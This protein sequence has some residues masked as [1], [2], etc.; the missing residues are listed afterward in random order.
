MRS[1][2]LTI[3]MG[4]VF[5]VTGADIAE[6]IQAWETETGG[7]PRNPQERVVE[8]PD[9]MSLVLLIGQSNM[10]GRADIP[11]EDRKPLARALKLNRD[12][13]WVPATA[14]FHFDRRT[15]GIGPANAFVKRYLAEHPKE[16]VGI[17][18]CAVGG[19]R[20]ATWDAH[21]TGKVGAN[22]R[23]A[24]K[25]A[26]VAKGKGR[27]VAILWHQGESDAGATA[28]ELKSHYP[29]RFA[30]MIAAFRQEIGD[31]PVVVGEIGRFLPEAAAKVNPVLA[32]L[33]KSVPN[34]RCVSSEGLT[35]RDKWHFDLKSANE[36]GDRYYAAFRELSD[37]KGC[38][39]LPQGKE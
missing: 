23:R 2:L 19:S 39:P 20:S 36:L 31:V 18:P 13:E 3:V 1:L 17:V 16:T 6:E 11:K 9:G 37:L 4:C 14:P 22:F 27:F 38:R 33:P 8:A 30:D 26:Q 12:D 29:R 10:A 28:E 32:A 34:C 7:L 15:A 21:G 24:L 35:N 5:S 25:R